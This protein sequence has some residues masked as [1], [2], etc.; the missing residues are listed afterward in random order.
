MAKYAESHLELVLYCELKP[1]ITLVLYSLTCAAINPT[2]RVFKPPFPKNPV[3]QKVQFQSQLET[4][5]NRT[6]RAAESL[7][8]CSTMKGSA[9]EPA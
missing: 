9:V 3:I 6:R 1:R 7:M 5:G 4:N 2:Q 8:V